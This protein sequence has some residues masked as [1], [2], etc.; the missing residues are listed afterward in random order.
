[1]KKIL[2]HRLLFAFLLTYG[3]VV[4]EAVT[5]PSQSYTSPDY[6][7]SDGSYSTG[8][9]GYSSMSSFSKLGS[10]NPGE[11]ETACTS[12]YSPEVDPTGVR[13]SQ[14]CSN[15]YEDCSLHPDECDWDYSTDFNNCKSACDAYSVPL[16]APLWFMLALAAVGAA[17][18]VT[19]RR[20][21]A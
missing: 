19:L 3:F 8:I 6:N 4:A 14:C 15:M 13:C 1:M 5:L 18:S 2:A 9:Q 16:D 17:F 21:L 10:E 11:I 12:T 20:R 7:Y